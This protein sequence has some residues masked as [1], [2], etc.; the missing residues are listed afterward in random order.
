MSRVVVRK[1]HW[2]WWVSGIENHPLAYST[3]ETWAEAMEMAPGYV[4]IANA[5]RRSRDALA[6]AFDCEFP[7]TKES[8]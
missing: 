2:G 4:A 3:H 7:P 8:A 5:E 1:L 6:A